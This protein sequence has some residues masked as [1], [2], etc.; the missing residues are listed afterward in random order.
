MGLSRLWPWDYMGGGR[1]KDDFQD[2]IDWLQ[3]HTLYPVLYSEFI[4]MGE[5]E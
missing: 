4:Q 5:E 3:L 1:M 2:F